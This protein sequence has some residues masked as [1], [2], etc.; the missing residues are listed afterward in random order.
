MTNPSCVMLMDA[1]GKIKVSQ[2]L[3]ILT[4]TRKVST[5]LGWMTSPIH[6]HLKDVERRQK[7]GRVLTT[8]SSTLNA[9]TKMKTR[10]ISSAG[11]FGYLKHCCPSTNISRSEY[12]PSKAGPVLETLLSTPL[13]ITLAGAGTGSSNVKSLDDTISPISLNSGHD[14]SRLP[15]YT[16]NLSDLVVNVHRPTTKS[17]MR[18]S[19]QDKVL[20]TVTQQ[21]VGVRTRR[22]EAIAQRSSSEVISSATSNLQPLEKQQSKPHPRLSNAP[23]SKTDQQLQVYRKSTQVSNEEAKAPSSTPD[24]A[25]L[26]RIVFDV[27]SEES[28]HRQMAQTIVSRLLEKFTKSTSVTL[29]RPTPENSSSSKFFTCSI[30]SSQVSRICDLNK[31]MKRHKRPYGCTYPKC[32]KRFGAKSDWKRHENSQHYQ[33]EAFRCAHTLLDTQEG[34]GKYFCRPEAF[35]EHL[36]TEHGL[37][38]TPMTDN[39]E[40]SRI[41]KNCQE[42]HWC[43]FCQEI[44]PLKEKRNEAWDE[45]FDHIAHHFE[46]EKKSIDDWLCA[47]ANKT[48]KQLRDEC[49]EFADDKDTLEKNSPNHDS[50]DIDAAGESD[51]SETYRSTSP[52]NQLKRKRTTAPPSPDESMMKKPVLTWDCVCTA[53]TYF[54][55]LVHS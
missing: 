39:F 40:R 50:P 38:S 20:P 49:D 45:R 8:S 15:S 6:A 5:R 11:T 25:E 2:L 36:A 10:T 30:C 53:L 1:L 9:Y 44:R 7:C 35:K 16:D 31:H 13:N 34:C 54:S 32:N 43:G 3:T 41:G 33:L 46:K 51:D 48:K 24:R 26:E 18:S 47:E 29:R 19:Q 52:V 4:A 14:M 22:A 37:P 12:R 23:Q 55:L 27:L 42:Q 28:S 17:T 21:Q